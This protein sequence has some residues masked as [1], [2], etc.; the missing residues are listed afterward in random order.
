MSRWLIAGKGKR[1]KRRQDKLQ[2]QIEMDNEK[3][4][5]EYDAQKRLEEDR[6]WILNSIEDG[7]LV[8]GDERFNRIINTAIH[9]Y[10]YFAKELLRKKII[11]REDGDLFYDAVDRVLRE[12]VVK[13]Y[14]YAVDWLLDSGI[15]TEQD[16][17]LYNR[18]LEI[19]TNPRYE[20]QRSDEDRLANELFDNYIYER[21]RFEKDRIKQRQ[22][23]EDPKHRIL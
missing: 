11:T 17:D 15:V 3:N 23:L 6:D 1:E 5:K 10:P 2:Q 9:K 7:T 14:N 8:N 13:P 4:R 18:A 22:M 20:K 21:N 16:G 12:S 19:I